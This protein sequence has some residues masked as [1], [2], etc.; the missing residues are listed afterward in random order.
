[1]K[2]VLPVTALPS[3]SAIVI[4][5][6]RTKIQEYK[7]FIFDLA[8]TKI[9]AILPQGIPIETTLFGLFW[10]AAT[11]LTK[12]P[13][14]SPKSTTI[15][16]GAILGDEDSSSGKKRKNMTIENV[17]DSGR[18]KKGGRKPGG[19]DWSTAEVQLLLRLVEEE[20]PCGRDM[21]DNVAMLCSKMWDGDDRWV[22]PGDACKKKFE[23]LAFMKAPTG[24]AEVPVD[25]RKAKQLLLKIEEK[26]RIGILELNDSDDLSCVSEGKKHEVALKGARLFDEESKVARRPVTRNTTSR[27]IAGS[28]DRMSSTQL[29]ATKML[30]D[31]LRDIGSHHGENSDVGTKKL[32]DL[33]MKIESLDEKFGTHMK[34]VND[35]LMAIMAMIRNN[36]N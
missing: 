11:S 14:V 24:T 8:S 3:L 18:K 28:L 16:N 2:I 1:M 25:V 34:N 22:R 29:D 20:L 19:K 9:E 23:K 31:A 12:Q 36:N 26:E 17:H 13:R 7:D 6:E 30:C 15:H 35:N 33:E 27:D 32:Q 5:M 10:K 21:W 4:A